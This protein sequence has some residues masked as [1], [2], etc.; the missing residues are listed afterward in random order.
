M[1]S[2]SPFPEEKDEIFNL[3]KRLG[4][5]TE[6]EGI[7]YYSSD[8]QLILWLGNIADFIETSF[9]DE[10]ASNL[11]EQESSFLIDHK[12]SVYLAALQKVSPD[13]FIIF[14]RLLT[15]IPEFKT[16]YLKDYHFLKSKLLD[17][18]A[19]DYQ[20]FRDDVSGF[21]RL[22]SR[23]KDGY[24]GQPGSQ[25]EIRSLLF[26]LWNDAQ[27]NEEQKIVAIVSLNPLTLSAK[28]THQKENILLVFYMLL[29]LSLL[30]LLIYFVKSPSFYKE[31]KSL[32]GLLVILI[33][34]FFC[35]FLLHLDSHKI[36]C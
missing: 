3:F 34:S 25:E 23:H 1:I 9:T 10:N 22:F 24:F 28:L 6:I 15:F 36:S 20:D 13:E 32:P 7:G 16:P 17:N 27:T 31:R 12:S 11:L 2:S 30:S 4:L 19:I 26:P 33:L 8:G 29:G 5:D 18:S 21:E 14:Y 35:K